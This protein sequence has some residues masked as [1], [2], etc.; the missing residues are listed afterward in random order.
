MKK[1]S[2]LI[3]LILSVAVM[4]SCEK[5]LDKEP[6]TD[7]TNS[8]F[9]TSEKNVEMFANYFYN[10]WV[11]YGNGTSTNGVFYWQT[12]NDNQISS[13]FQDW[14]SRT[15]DASNGTWNGSYTEIRRAN[16]LIEKV[17]GIEGMSDAAKNHWVGVGRLYRALY[18]YYLV[19]SFGDCVW[20]DHVLDVTEEDRDG[21]IFS[22]RTDRDIVMDK[23]LE[24]LNFAVSNIRESSSRVEM[25]RAI[26][27]AIKSEICLYEGTFCKY[28]SSADGQ[29]AADSGRAQKFL[30]ECK[31]A[32]EAIINNGNYALGASY[33]AVYNSIDLNGNKEMIMYKKYALENSFCHSLIDYTCSSTM[34]SGMSKA[35]FDSYLFR[36]GNCLAN[37][38]LDKNDHAVFTESGSTWVADISEV[39]ANRDPRLSESIDANLMYNGTPYQRYGVGHLT[40]SSSGYGVLKFDTNEIPVAYRPEGGKNYT[41]APIFWLAEILLNHAEAC[42]ELGDNA[43]AV[44]SINK[45]RARAGMPNLTTSPA[46]DPANN[47]GVSDLIWEVRRERRVEMMYDKND[48]Y[49]SLIRWHQLDKLD[50]SKYPD[51][52]KGAWVGNHLT[53]SSTAKA[54]ANGYIDMTGK[55]T[56]TYDKKHYLRP[57]PSGQ[58]DLNPNLGQNPGW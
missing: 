8:N 4:A 34:Q 10:E 47:M 55:G 2:N 14:Y 35:A 56:R 9:W 23:V 18:H 13:G 42:V 39:L 32:S 33:R 27:Q 54:D 28:R 6:L 31:T 48:R 22:A 19:R 16:T 25:N 17:P 51:I 46:A 40:T 15:V 53:E 37:T 43:A 1:I 11:G 52:A 58:L 26:A 20:V 21:F 49:W 41:D 44:N 50:T 29:K 30:T 7:F 36:D 45:L 24:D 3:V 57:I 12:L 38:T 5:V